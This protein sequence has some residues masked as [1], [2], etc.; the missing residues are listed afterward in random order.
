MIF[1]SIAKSVSSHCWQKMKD[2]G[3]CCGDLLW[4]Q[5]MNIKRVNSGNSFPVVLEEESVSQEDDLQ[6]QSPHKRAQTVQ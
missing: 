1:S 2:V 3:S 5:N 6:S 4:S